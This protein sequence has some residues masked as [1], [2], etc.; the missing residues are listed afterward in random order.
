M[1]A[2]RRNNHVEP[3]KQ[4]MKVVEKER[5]TKNQKN[6]ACMRAQKMYRRMPLAAQQPEAR[7]QKPE[8]RNHNCL[9]CTVWKG[10]PCCNAAC[11]AP[12]LALP[13]E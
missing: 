3:N 7:S 9:Y 11:F 1:N 10:N 2:I 6:N 8:A 12:V 5:K 13:E 4:K